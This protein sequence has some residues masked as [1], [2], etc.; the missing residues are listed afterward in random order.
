MYHKVFKMGRRENLVI[1]YPLAVSREERGGSGR[2]GGRGGGR[3]T[4]LVAFL[5]WR[6]STTGVVSA[7]EGQ[8]YHMVA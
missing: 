6:C 7:L 1:P 5:D 4:L 2:G 8:V 3:V